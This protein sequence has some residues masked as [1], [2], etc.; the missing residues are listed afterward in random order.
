M[1]LAVSAC[2]GWTGVGFKPGREDVGSKDIQV[3]EAMFPEYSK[4]QI[5]AVIAPDKEHLS[6]A[7]DVTEAAWKMV[8]SLPVRDADLE[9]GRPDLAAMQDRV[10]VLERQLRL[11][12]VLHAYESNTKLKNS[13]AEK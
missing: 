7:K 4:E 6:L 11:S 5:A 9:V 3:L 13:N 10:D 1:H 2:Y 8:E 12:D